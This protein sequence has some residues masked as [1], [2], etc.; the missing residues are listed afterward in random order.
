MSARLL[1]TTRDELRLRALETLVVGFVERFGAS[2]AVGGSYA[3]SLHTRHNA[4]LPNDLDLVT[5]DPSLLDPFLEECERVSALSFPAERVVLFSGEIQSVERLVALADRKNASRVADLIACQLTVIP[6]SEMPDQLMSLDDRD[7]NVLGFSVL[8]ANKLH[9]LWKVRT[10]SLVSSRVR[11][12]YDLARVAACPEFRG[13][14]DRA[15]ALAGEMSSPRRPL[16][17]YPREWIPSWRDLNR[18]GGTTLGLD[19]AWRDLERRA[20]EVT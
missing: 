1:R 4:R 16:G 3:V 14:L 6:P 8:L 19:D 13:H 20:L 9:A 18:A 2:V 7:V 15:T 12:L 17:S 10:T 5:D 11:D